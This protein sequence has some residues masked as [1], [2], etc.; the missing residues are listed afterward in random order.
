[1]R[2]YGEEEEV[3]SLLQMLALAAFPFVFG[4][5]YLIP[6]MLA[7]LLK[8]FV[9]G[10]LSNFLSLEDVCKAANQMYSKGFS[11]EGREACSSLI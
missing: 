5:F 1:M 3:F 10:V 4:G 8:L 9:P 6:P 2:V 11:A 7:V